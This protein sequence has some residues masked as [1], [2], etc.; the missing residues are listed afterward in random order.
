[1]EISD[2]KKMQN[3]FI[4][5]SMVR[6]VKR[7]ANLTREEKKKVEWIRKELSGQAGN[8]K[9][10]YLKRRKGNKRMRNEKK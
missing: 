6:I 2:K 3:N 8:G 10:R 4:V 9:E 1:M 7:F 5:R